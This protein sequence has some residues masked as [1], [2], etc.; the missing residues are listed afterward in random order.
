MTTGLVKSQTKTELIKSQTRIGFSN[1]SKPLKLTENYI[2]LNIDLST[3]DINRPDDSFFINISLALNGDKESK[4]IIFHD[5]IK[6]IK[7]KSLKESVVIKYPI[8]RDS[9]VKNDILNFE[10]TLKD[11]SKNI[12][13]Y[14]DKYDVFVLNTNVENINKKSKY[15]FHIGTNFDLKNKFE[16]NSFYSEIDVFLPN[17]AYSSFGIRAGIYKNNSVSTL[18]NNKIDTEIITFEE[19]SISN[20]SITLLINRVSYTPTVSYENIGLYAGVIYNIENFD[21]KKEKFEL[22]ASLNFE[23][24]QRNESYSYKNDVL[25]PLGSSRISLDSLANNV[26]LQNKLTRNINSDRSVKYYSHSIGL[27]LPMLYSNE[28]IEVSLNPTFGF[29][30]IGLSHRINSFASIQFYLMENKFGIKLSGDIRRYWGSAQNPIITINLSKS[31]N[32]SSLFEKG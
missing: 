18:S 30:S 32:L 25:F 1:S 14:Q 11:N 7:I 22:Y 24:I 6:E 8:N 17:I 26:S 4:K 19:N 3:D 28:S 23:I 12:E 16:T 15:N 20:D 21:K 13:L 27:G 5:L 9:I 10:I 31:F 29:G 2:K